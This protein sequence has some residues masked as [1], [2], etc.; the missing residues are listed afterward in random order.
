M[1]DLGHRFDEAVTAIVQQGIDQGSLRPI[2]G[3]AKV[4]AYGVIG[5][6]NWTHRWF[7]PKGPLSAEQIGRTYA[8]LMLD[9]LRV[10]GLGADGHR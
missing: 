10:G 4:I 8:E 6:C 7:D 1:R 9:G 5:L 2:G 3:S